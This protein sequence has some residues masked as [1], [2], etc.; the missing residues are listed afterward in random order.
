MRQ[1]KDILNMA[2]NTIDSHQHFWDLSINK[3]PWLNNNN[4]TLYRNYLPKD[5]YSIIK[6]HKVCATVLVQASPTISETQYLLELSKHNKKIKAVVGWVDLSDHN[7]KKILKYFAKNSVFKG[8]RPMIQDI[9]D[10]NWI[11]NQTN[12]DIIQLLSDLDFTM[13]LLINKKHIKNIIKFIEK[14]PNIPMVINHF[15]KPDLD[16]E[17]LKIWIKGISNLSNYPNVYAK[18]SGLL[19]QSNTIDF[20]KIERYFDHYFYYFSPERIMWGSDWPVL[21]SNGDYKT[22][23]STCVKYVKKNYI[24]SFDDVFFNVANNFYSMGLASYSQK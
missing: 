7:S 17:D 16:K 6:T 20:I 12:A 5:L 22:W 23:L 18:M 24:D 3:Y 9:N 19:T 14:W 8:V 11:N 10:H 15:A 13:D 4:Y 2:N 21:M 1:L